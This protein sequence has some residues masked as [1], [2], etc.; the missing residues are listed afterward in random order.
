MNA[1]LIAQLTTAGPPFAV[2]RS[3]RVTGPDAAAHASAYERDPAGYALLS[4]RPGVR[5]EQRA[6]ILL[7]LLAPSRL[8]MDAAIPRRRR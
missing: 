8:G 2:S 1:E 6:R 3:G 7:Q 4:L 5:V